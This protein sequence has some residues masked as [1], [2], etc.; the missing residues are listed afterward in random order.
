MKR[1]P[2]I[3]TFAEQSAVESELTAGNSIRDL[4]SVPVQYQGELDELAA[5]LVGALDQMIDDIRVLRDRT[6]RFSQSVDRDRGELQQQ[7]EEIELLTS[8]D[9]DLSN[10]DAE[11]GTDPGALFATETELVN[12]LRK[13]HALE[14]SLADFASVI[15]TAQR[16]LQTGSD[17]PDAGS[18]SF[19]AIK[20]AEM[21]AREEE[22]KRFARDIHDGPAQ[23]FANAIIGLEFIDRALKSD[24]DSVIEDSLAEIERIK[25]T[26]R[27]GLTEIRRFIFDNRPTMLLDRGLGPTLR[28]YV[29]NYQS[30]FPM[31]VNIEIDDE[32]GR[33]DPDSELAAFRVVQESIQNASKHARASQ[34]DV[35]IVEA[36]DGGIKVTVTDNGRGFNPERVSAHAMGGVGLKGME[37]RIALIGGSLDIR[38]Q[39]GE[40]TTIK[41]TLPKRHG[42]DGPDI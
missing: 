18:A 34:V 2:E 40:G 16:Q 13:S 20:M 14:R 22:R 26:M 36:D 23:A 4:S 12:H 35:R 42:E 39:R 5:D 31:I 1:T 27:E 8:L 29:Q 3:R 9:L 11:S 15:L 24:R 6:A 21:R 37:E 25:R 19:L 17:L 10:A 32:L 30:I 38:S 33:L 41:L 28:H 7:R